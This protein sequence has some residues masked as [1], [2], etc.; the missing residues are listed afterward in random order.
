[1]TQESHGRL[2]G[3]VPVGRLRAKLGSVVVAAAMLASALVGGCG[4]SANGAT[5]PATITGTLT[6]PG[7]ASGASAFA[8]VIDS[9]ATAASPIAETT[10]TTTGATTLDYAITQVPAG[11]YFLLGFVD[12]DGSGGTSSTTGDYRG[13][14]G[15]TGDG[16]PP[17]VANVV[18]PASGTVTFDFSLIIAP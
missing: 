6:L 5:G 9:I 13:W 17:A 11:T 15:H 4:D 7:T 18:V 3:G 12:V 14:F 10:A 16:N 2:D 1:M 8:R